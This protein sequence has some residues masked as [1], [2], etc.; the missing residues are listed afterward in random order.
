MV[1][2]TLQTNRG[3]NS[4]AWPFTGYLGLTP[5]TLHGSLSTY[6][7]EDKIELEASSVIV[8]AACYEGDIS[9]P[10]GAATASRRL[11]E[12]SKVLWTPS[13][14]SRFAA[15]GDFQ[16]AWHLTIP[17]NAREQ[18]AVSTLN[19]KTWRVWWVVEAGTS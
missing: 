16:H 12:V 8:R 11:F 2:L 6:I 9:C 7:E 10:G 14:G 3:N 15:L 5:V 1:K 19:F 18:G 4:R 17:P 13:G